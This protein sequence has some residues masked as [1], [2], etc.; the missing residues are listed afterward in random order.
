MPLAADGVSARLLA[1]TC[2]R[3]LQH[4]VPDD[5][6]DLSACF[7]GSRLGIFNHVVQECAAECFDV[8]H[9]AMIDEKI[10]QSNRVVDVRRGIL[11]L[12]A[13]IL[14]LARGEFESP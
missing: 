7:S 9:M 12:A 13:L 4:D 3:S 6:P 2:R 11:V 1:K 8:S 10:G 5:L 14:V